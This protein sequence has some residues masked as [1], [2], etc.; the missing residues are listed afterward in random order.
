MAPPILSI[1]RICR[2]NVEIVHQ[3]RSRLLVKYV[4]ETDPQSAAAATH[5]NF[6][7]PLCACL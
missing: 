1:E 7:D 6:F 4:A 5:P 3:D 2:S